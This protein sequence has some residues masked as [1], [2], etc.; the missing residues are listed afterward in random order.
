[1]YTLQALWTAARENLNITTVVFANRAYAI[2]KGE[3]AALGGNPGPRALDMLD[4]GR[5]DIDWVSLSKSLGIPARRAA[6]LDEFAK[7][8]R[9]GFMSDGPTLIEIPL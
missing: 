8:L 5:P 1:M 2:L 9:H 3:L 7:A 4:I 6:T